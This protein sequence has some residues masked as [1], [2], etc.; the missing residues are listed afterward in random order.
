M[1]ELLIGMIIGIILALPLINAVT[2]GTDGGLVT[3]S[4]TAA[5]S[6]SNSPFSDS[7]TYAERVL[8]PSLINI[9]E[10]GIYITGAT[11]AQN[12]TL[13]IYDG[14]IT[15]PINL[16]RNVSFAKGTT[17]GWKR[18]AITPHI[19]LNASTYY[20]LAY[21]MPATPTFTRVK[22]TSL[23]GHPRN[24]DTS[25][26][27]PNPYITSYTSDYISAVYANYTSIASPNTCTP[28]ASGNWAI[29]CSD[30]CTWNTNLVIPQNIT[31]TGTGTLTLNKNMTFSGSNK[32]IFMN[33]G[34]QL[35]IN[36]G[37]GFG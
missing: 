8:T 13:G 16:I 6:G 21:G 30:N 9:T 19:Q 29:T 10:M 4:P 28:P 17:S 11:E 18:I 33:R 27:F 3:T 32:Y 35:N 23:G 15:T 26:L 5:P 37:G 1:K 36:R 2:D 24:Q 22:L 12:I 14:N 34:C 31:I 25:G 7:I 20:W